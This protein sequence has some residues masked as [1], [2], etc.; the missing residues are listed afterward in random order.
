MKSP[1]GLWTTKS[2]SYR[3]T[4]PKDYLQIR[5]KKFHSVGIISAPVWYL[6]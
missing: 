4:L 2:V 3:M 6:R 5:E 1:N